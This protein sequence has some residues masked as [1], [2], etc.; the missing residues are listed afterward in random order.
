MIMCIRC[1]LEKPPIEFYKNKNTKNGFNIYCKKCFRDLCVN[2]DKSKDTLKKWK[3]NNPERLKQYNAKQRK[4]NK[5]N[6]AEYMAIWRKNNKEHIREYRKN[7]KEAS[8]KYSAKWREKNPNY[9]NEYY[10][11]R[12]N[13]DESFKLQDNLRRRFRKALNGHTKKSSVL[14]YLC[15]SIED[16]KKQLEKQFKPEMNWENY[17]KIWHIDHIHPIVHFDHSDE[18]NIKKCWHY[19]NLQP[20]FATTEIAKSF[21]YK[22][23]NGNLNKPKYR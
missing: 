20:L 23:E 9:I 16:L 6:I 4:K 7:N 2:N 10:K 3:K 11:K 1:K 21:G 13:T 15:C 17:G 22:N 18:N 14:K 5:E 19:S 12:R 8:N